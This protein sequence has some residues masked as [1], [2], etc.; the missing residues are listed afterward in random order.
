MSFSLVLVSGIRQAD[1]GREGVQSV[2]HEPVIRAVITYI[3]FDEVGVPSHLLVV[4]HVC[5]TEQ[6]YVLVVS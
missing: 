5:R 4:A 2:A 3:P 6:V 1:R